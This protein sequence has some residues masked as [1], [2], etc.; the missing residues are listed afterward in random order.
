MLFDKCKQNKRAFASMQVIIG[1]NP[2]PCTTINTDTNKKQVISAALCIVWL[3]TYFTALKFSV[4][5]WLARG[6]L[7]PANE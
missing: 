3:A 2:S 6:A 4:L 5:R 1:V 7:V